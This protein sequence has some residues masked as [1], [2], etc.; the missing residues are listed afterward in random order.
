MLRHINEAEEHYESA[1]GLLPANA[2]NDLG[3]THNQLGTILANAGRL[4]VA[5]QH[6]RKSIRYKEDA[7]N[8]YGAAVTRQNVAVTLA[9]DGRLTD[10]MHYAKAALDNF[11]T[12]GDRASP[13]I[14]QTLQLVARIDQAL[15]AKGAGA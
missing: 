15:K 10:A 5:L 6:Y 2:I 9:Q 13:E 1:L 4:D 11:Q 3:V 7:H 14:L 8:L 12:Y